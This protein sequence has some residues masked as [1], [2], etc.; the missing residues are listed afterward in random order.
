MK[1][2]TN[3]YTNTTNTNTTLAH[4]SCPTLL[5]ALPTTTTLR[6]V[7]QVEYNF[8][9]DSEWTY[10]DFSCKHEGIAKLWSKAKDIVKVNKCMNK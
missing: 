5:S 9:Y 2:N 7:A 1:T 6:Y 8:D 3:I 4:S 10:R